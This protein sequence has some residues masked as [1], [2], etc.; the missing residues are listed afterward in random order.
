MTTN[1][2]PPPAGYKIVPK[3]EVP[4]PVPAGTLILPK[5]APLRAWFPSAAVGSNDPHDL[6]EGNFHAIP[7]S[8]AALPTEHSYAHLLQQLDE[9]DAAIAELNQRLIDRT[10][11]LLEM[12]VLYTQEI[13]RL[14]R[15]THS[16][17]Q[18]Q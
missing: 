11:A 14:R 12:H 1:P 2:P 4:L 6:W 5:N 17:S 13:V 7:D 10:D 3:E 16:S 9:K 18:P 8:T 15:L